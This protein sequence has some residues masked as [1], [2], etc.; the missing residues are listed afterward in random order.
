MKRFL[1]IIFS[2]ELRRKDTVLEPLFNQHA[3]DWLRFGGTNWIAWTEHSPAQWN[4]LVKPFLEGNDQVV[5]YGINNSDRSGI[6]HKWIWDWLDKNR[7]S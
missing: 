7:Y 1:V 4:N 3:D 5:I 2:F 6:L